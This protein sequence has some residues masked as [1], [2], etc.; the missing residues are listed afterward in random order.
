MWRWTLC[1]SSCRCSCLCL[2]CLRSSSVASMSK[3]LH[4]FSSA[5]HAT[6]FISYSNV[7]WCPVLHCLIFESL[8]SCLHFRCRHFGGLCKFSMNFITGCMLG[9]LSCSFE[10]CLLEV[11]SVSAVLLP[12]TCWFANLSS[13]CELLFP[14]WSYRAARNQFERFRGV[15]E[16]L[17]D[18]N[19]IFVAAG[20]FFW[21]IRI[22]GV[23]KVQSH[24]TWPYMCMCRGLFVPTHFH[25][26]C[27][28]VRDDIYLYIYA[29]IYRWR[30]MWTYT[31]MYLNMKKHKYFLC[32]QVYVK[33]PWSGKCFE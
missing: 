3:L 8:H 23:F 10:A 32:V 24:T 19:S 9:F 2:W 33:I 11:Q 18:S 14:L 17:A 27:C 25:F 15:F 21:T 6:W 12:V 13:I 31:N 5:S 4:C 28:G 7:T 30:D 29:N 1:W 22:F 20:F 26:E 16:F